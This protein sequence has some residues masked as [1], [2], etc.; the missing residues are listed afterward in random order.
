VECSGNSCIRVLVAQ[1]TQELGG[2]IPLVI[3]DYIVSVVET[4]KFRKFGTR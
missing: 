4:G 1:K 2:R 3:E